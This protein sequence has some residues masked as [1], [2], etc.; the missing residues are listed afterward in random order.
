MRYNG[1]EKVVTPPEGGG[2]G[3]DT[4]LCS[5]AERQAAGPASAVGSKILFLVQAGQWRAVD[6]ALGAMAVFALTD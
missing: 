2:D 6:R 4:F 1:L 3:D 5:L